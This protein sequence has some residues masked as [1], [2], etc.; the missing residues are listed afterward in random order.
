[1]LLGLGFSSIV[2]VV[3][4]VAPAIRASRLQPIDAL[5]HE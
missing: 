1:V 3:F 2:G 4:G 5:R